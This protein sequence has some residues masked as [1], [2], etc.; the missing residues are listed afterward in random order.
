MLDACLLR[1]FG[2]DELWVQAAKV[3]Q[4]AGPAGGQFAPDI[5]ELFASWEQQEGIQQVMGKWNEKVT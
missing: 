2:Q 4:G 1:S 3:A 5:P